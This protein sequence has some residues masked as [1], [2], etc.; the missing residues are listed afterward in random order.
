MPVPGI[1]VGVLDGELLKPKGASQL[2][3]GEAPLTSSNGLLQLPPRAPLSGMTSLKIII[4]ETK[5]II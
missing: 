4:A 5:I 1:T 3:G 2:N